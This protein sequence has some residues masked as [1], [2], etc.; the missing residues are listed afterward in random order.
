MHLLALSRGTD[1]LVTALRE[2]EIEAYISGMLLD[3]RFKIQQYRADV[4]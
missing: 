2:L 1:V 3:S 4:T